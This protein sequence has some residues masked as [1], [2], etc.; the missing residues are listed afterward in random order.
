MKTN[1]YNPRKRNN[2]GL[3]HF[4]NEIYFSKLR[5]PLSKKAWF[6]NHDFTL[7]SEN[8]AR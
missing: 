8:K 5:M 2:I 7:L 1:R 6:I 4:L 3:M